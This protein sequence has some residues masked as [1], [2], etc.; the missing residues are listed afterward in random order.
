M[1]RN[2]T[3][4]NQHIGKIDKILHNDEKCADGFIRYDNNRSVYFRL[5][6]TDALIK[7][8]RVGLEVTFTIL[9]P[10][11]DGKKGRAINIKHS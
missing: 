5:H 4:R 6:S 10:K 11:E 3:D 7:T 8:L 9:P 1:D 2:T